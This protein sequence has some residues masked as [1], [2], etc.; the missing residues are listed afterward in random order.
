MPTR[1]TF[2]TTAAAGL[3]AT[4]IAPASALAQRSRQELPTARARSL[5][6]KFGL[7]YPVL[8]APSGGQ[9]LAAAI[10]NAGGIGAFALWRTS[11]DVARTN[12]ERMRTL[13]RKPFIVNYVLT[14]EPESLPAALEAGAPI[15]QFSWGVPTPAMTAD[16]RKAGASFGV[17][18]ATPG[19]AR[20]AVDA[21]AAYLV[22]QGVEAGG[23]GQSS[24]PLK[25]LLPRVL[26]EAGDVPV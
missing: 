25:D 2:L 6:S 20:A 10:S 13:T 22:A 8:Q 14:F 11:A 9:E 4:V 3:G 24:T 26:A 17:Q 18:V 16:I 7:N 21:G 19:G 15:V 5:M 12:V 1:R 23:H